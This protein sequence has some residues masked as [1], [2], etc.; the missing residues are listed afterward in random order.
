[1]VR[2]QVLFHVSHEL[3]ITLSITFDLIQN[4]AEFF[5]LRQIALVLVNV[6]FEFFV[7][8]REGFEF[9]GPH[10]RSIFKFGDVI[11]QEAN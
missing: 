5:D 3:Q 11:D 10:V 8:G 6:E 1:M 7:F 9:M 2:R 4:R